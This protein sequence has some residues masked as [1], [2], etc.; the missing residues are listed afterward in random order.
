MGYWIVIFVL[1]SFVLN[2]ITGLIF[3]RHP[4]N[5]LSLLII[6]LIGSIVAKGKARTAAKLSMLPGLIILFLYYVVRPLLL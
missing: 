1:L 4:I 6:P 2:Q 5:I 3:G